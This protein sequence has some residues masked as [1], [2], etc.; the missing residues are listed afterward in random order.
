MRVDSLHSEAYKV[1]GGINRVGQEDGSGN[2]AE[3][4]QRQ[5]QSDK[6]EGGNKKEHDRK[7]SP[8]STLEASFEALNVKKFDVAFT[9]D[10]LYHQTSAQFDEGGVKGLLLNNLG[11]YGCCRVLFDSSEVPEKCILNEAQN[12]KSELI[13]LS[14]AKEYIE[15]MLINMP[16][17][18]HISPTLGEI[19]NRFDEGK[20]KA[21]NVCFVEQQQFFHDGIDDLEHSELG[22][23]SFD[24]FG[25]HTFDD[26][27]H[28][29]VVDDSS[30][31]AGP[32]FQ[33]E[34]GEYSFQDD[35]DNRLEEIADFLSLGLGFTSKSNAWAGPDHWKYRKIKGVFFSLSSINL[36]QYFETIV[37]S[38]VGADPIPDL[39]DKSE[40]PT[41]KAKVRTAA[42]DIDFTKSL[43]EQ[44]PDIFVYPKNPK[45]L[46]LPATR[47]PCSITLPEDCH[48]RPESLVKLFL[49]PDVMCLGKK[50][51]ITSD[52]SSEQHDGFV[53]YGSWDSESISEGH[54]DDGSFDNDVEDLGA[55]VQPSRQVN[56]VD[57][58][59]DKVSKQVD[60][61][62]LKET[63]WMHIAGTAQMSN[64]EQGS[65]ASVSLTQVMHHL[66][67]TVPLESEKDISPHL[68]FICLLHLANEHGLTL[69]HP[70]TLDNVDI[71]I[72]AA[73]YS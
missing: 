24:D 46:L 38:V 71:H 43:E 66:R 39:V 55:L 51:R 14:F 62:A 25:C 8:L 53:P 18:S 64:F 47:A 22:S 16:K 65:E 20:L 13:D 70:P 37:N 31:S 69:H 29:S 17:K 15:E 4:N 49:L 34:V 9:V 63:L 59:Y 2:S 26:E 6:I 23:N 21:Q 36:F 1:L 7:L 28:V 54:C 60:V 30:I 61:H 48:Y 58:Q 72:P 12:N 68:F 3:E 19:L 32:D 67:L 35:T 27:D 10:P 11:V 5:D 41:R 57:I 40:L 42:S 52:E 73:L 33:E 50:T 56:K 44:F 45:S